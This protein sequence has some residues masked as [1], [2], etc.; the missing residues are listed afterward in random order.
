MKINDY[1]QDRIDYHLRQSRL[2][3]PINMTSYHTGAITAYQDIQ[4][5]LMVRRMQFGKG[6]DI[7]IDGI[8]ELEK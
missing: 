4:V 8:E 1:L 3:Q 5:K 7:E 2:K 6:A